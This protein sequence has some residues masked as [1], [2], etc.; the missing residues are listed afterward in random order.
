MTQF[1]LEQKAMALFLSLGDKTSELLLEQ[2]EYLTVEKREF[3]GIGFYTYYTTPES[4]SIDNIEKRYEGLSVSIRNPEDTMCFILYIKKGSIRC[5]EA[6]TFEGWKQDDLGRLD[7]TTFYG[8]GPSSFV[9][10]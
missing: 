7:I 1:E 3:T 8:G 2:L 9:T 4:Q 6:Y 5:L 10:R